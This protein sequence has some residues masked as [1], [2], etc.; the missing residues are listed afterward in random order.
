MPVA[1][2]KRWGGTL[3]MRGYEVAKRLSAVSQLTLPMKFRM[4]DC[5]E[6]AEILGVSPHI[7]WRLATDTRIALG[8]SSDVKERWRQ[9]AYHDHPGGEAPSAEQWLATAGLELDGTWKHP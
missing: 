8:Y 2:E 1:H 7:A 4:N 6:L 3:P 5:V 9:I